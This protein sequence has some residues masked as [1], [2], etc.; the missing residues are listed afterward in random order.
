MTP[1]GINEFFA[2]LYT[3]RVGEVMF[4]VRLVSGMITSALLAALVVVCL[5]FRELSA[6][7]QSVEEISP[8]T[9]PPDDAIRT[10]WQE[11]TRKI[12]SQNPSDWSSAVIQADAV[13][14]GVLTDMGLPGETMAD[15]LKS[16]APS[17][18]ASLNEV[19]EA[20]RVRNRIAHEHDATLAYDEAN[21]AVVSFGR[22]LCELHYLE[23]AGI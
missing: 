5:K 12:Q 9:P 14:D 10:S 11:I 19:W 22:A 20:H 16:F 2:F 8:P 4:W 15:R 17:Q 3:G 13:L 7:K 21:R 1:K 23:E 18:L 6:S